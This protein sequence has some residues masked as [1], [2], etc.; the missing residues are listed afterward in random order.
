LGFPARYRGGAEA[1]DKAG[2]QQ[3]RRCHNR[4]FVIDP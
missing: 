4:A 1:G 2:G 3:A